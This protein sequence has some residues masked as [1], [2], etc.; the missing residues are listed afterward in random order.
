MINV[1]YASSSAVILVMQDFGCHNDS[2]EM[3][4]ND[5][6]RLFLSNMADDEISF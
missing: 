4:A 1:S 3:K 6:S 5:S 2:V